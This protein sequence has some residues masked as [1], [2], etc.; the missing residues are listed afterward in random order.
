MAIRPRRLRGGKTVYDVMLRRP[1]GTQYSK[2]FTTKKEAESWQARQKVA[3]D[4]ERWVDPTAGRMVLGE[5]AREWMGARK[6]APG[7]ERSTRAS[8]STFSPPSPTHP[9]THNPPRGPDL[10]QQAL[11]TGQ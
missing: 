11:E 4:G 1:N 3:M 10:E 2:T 5:Y 9:S 7:P 6:L 8:S